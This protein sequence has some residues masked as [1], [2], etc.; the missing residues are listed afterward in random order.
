MEAIKKAKLQNVRFYVL[1]GYNTRIK[2]DL[3]RCQKI[4]D[5]GYDPYIM[6]FKKT[7]ENMRFKRFI[8][9]FMWRKYKTIEQAWENYT[10]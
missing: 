6:P 7:R 5:F 9:T 10:G 8:D 2:E 1:I 4:I 3:H